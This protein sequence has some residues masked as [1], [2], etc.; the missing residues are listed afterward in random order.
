MIIEITDSNYEEI[1]KDA[2][3]PLVVDFWAPWCGPCKTISPMVDELAE[4]YADQIV[5]AKCN[6]EDNDDVASAFD[7]RNIP[8][9][10]F[11]KDGQQVDK[12]VG[13][14][15]KGALAAKFEALL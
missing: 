6:V 14:L 11:F 1:T 7:I 4:Q 15:T 8:T 9:I 10:I 2:S 12:Q 13:S 3:K 5:V